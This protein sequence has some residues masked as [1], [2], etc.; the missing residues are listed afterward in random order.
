MSRFSPLVTFKIATMAM[1]LGGA[2]GVVACGGGGDSGDDTGGG[3]DSGGSS[4]GKGGSAGSKGGSGGS[5]GSGSG[6]S[7][8]GD[9]Q[10]RA[11]SNCSKGSTVGAIE[12]DVINKACAGS[13]C[14]TSSAFGIYKYSMTKSWA[15]NFF[16]KDSKS[17]CIGEKVI[18][19]AKPM[20]SLFLRLLYD[21]V[22]K[23]KDGTDAL[24]RMPRLPDPR[25]DADTIKCLEEYIKVVTKD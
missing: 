8:G 7:S 4:G 19:K 14:H 24:E 25:L 23:C 18:D 15:P 12:K 22:P 21:E 6:G 9:L 10:A 16:D 3:G 5:A 20:D 13:G 1:V 11:V 17:I 2:L